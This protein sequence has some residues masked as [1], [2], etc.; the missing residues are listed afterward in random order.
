MNIT[1]LTPPFSWPHQ[2]AMVRFRATMSHCRNF[3]AIIAMLKQEG[4]C[5]W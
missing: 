5:A 4:G 1:V 3:A 2:L